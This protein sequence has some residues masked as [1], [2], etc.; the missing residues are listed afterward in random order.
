M[1]R[2]KRIKNALKIFKIYYQ[3][4]R[5][6]KSK[7]DSLQEMTDDYQPSLVCIVENT[8]AKRRR[9]SHTRLYLVYCNDKSANNGGILIGVRD[10]IKNINLKLIQENKVGQS[11]WI[12]VTSTKKKLE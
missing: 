4:L 3:N 8:Q 9:N 12:L 10:N 1:K 2:S 5:G 7:L 6:I 11:P